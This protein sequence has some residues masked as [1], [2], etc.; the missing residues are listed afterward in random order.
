MNGILAVDKG[1]V[2]QSLYDLHY[3]NFDLT[4]LLTIIYLQFLF[5]KK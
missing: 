3:T 2:T 4:L 5:E 1:T